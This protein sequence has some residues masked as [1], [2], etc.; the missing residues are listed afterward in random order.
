MDGSKLASRIKIMYQTHNFP[1]WNIFFPETKDD[2]DRVYAGLKA[3][4]HVTAIKKEPI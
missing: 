4:K 2:E 1:H 3:L